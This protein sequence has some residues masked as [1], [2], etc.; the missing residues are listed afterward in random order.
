MRHLVLVLFVTAI[1]TSR[2]HA[3]LAAATP[4]AADAADAVVLNVRRT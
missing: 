4:D 2:C 3:E 1:Y